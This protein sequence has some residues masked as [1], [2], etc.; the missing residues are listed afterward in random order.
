M[1]LTQDYS[2]V[3]SE[4]SVKLS[5]ILSYLQNLPDITEILE[6]IKTIL[7]FGFFSLLLYDYFKPK[8]KGGA[9]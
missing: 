6:F 2:T 1:F 8:F 3:L 5:T 7:V 4:I 9:F